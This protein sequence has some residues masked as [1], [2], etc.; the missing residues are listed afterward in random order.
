M[1]RI[2]LIATVILLWAIN[3]IAQNHHLSNNWVIGGSVNYLQQK[4]AFP[5]ARIRVGNYGGTY[6][7]NKMHSEYIR[8]SSSAY[9][10][11]EL[12]S[13]WYIGL[14]VQNTRLVN[15]TFEDDSRQEIDRKTE[16]K[17]LQFELN[18][19]YKL[20]PKDKFMAILEP[21]VSYNRL[22]DIYSENL[23]NRDQEALYFEAGLNVGVL[24][25]LN[26]HWRF[27]FRIGGFSYISG[28][29]EEEGDSEPFEFSAF[30][31]NMSLT[32]IRIGMEY[33]INPISASELKDK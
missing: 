15:T 3:A 1:K 27:Q 20:N 25:Q 30:G 29:W 32:T 9:V 21:F 8:L 12:D 16:S 4:N 31:I 7:D 22:E 14:E 17:G 19:R 10:G 23:L 33:I 6:S 13:R 26:D 2:L 5:L 24:Y 11:K 18:S 28:E